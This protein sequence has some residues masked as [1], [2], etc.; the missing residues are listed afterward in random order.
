[1]K[2]K[3]SLWMSYI[4]MFIALQVAL[5]F[6]N[7]FIPSMPFGGSIAFSLIPIFLA[8]YLLG[9]KSGIIVGVG[10]SIVLF[11]V[12]LASF[13]GWWSVLLDYIIPLGVCG[14]AG[15]IKNKKLKNGLELPIGIWFSMLLKFMAHYASGVFLFYENTPANMSKYVYSFIYN[16]PYN[17]L[18]GIVCFILVMI[19]LPKLKNIIK[20]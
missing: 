7:E 2:I 6:I 19:L 13:W 1:M 12:G 3:K 4:A 14:L 15:L 9:V 5:E 11:A 16:L 20:V 18:T 10:S 8:S 17:V